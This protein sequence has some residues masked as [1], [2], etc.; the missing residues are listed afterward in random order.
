MYAEYMYMSVKNHE[1]CICI[2]MYANNMELDKR[3]KKPK[4]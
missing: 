4:L 3:T 2:K 1:N